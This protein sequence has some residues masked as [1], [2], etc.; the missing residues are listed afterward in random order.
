MIRAQAGRFV[1]LRGQGTGY[2]ARLWDAGVA[3]CVV[4]P[5]EAPLWAPDGL[6]RLRQGR[7]R[8][9]VVALELADPGETPALPQSGSRLYGMGL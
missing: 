2:R 9:P 5:G 8:V 6:R 1:G 7:P 3:A 4:R